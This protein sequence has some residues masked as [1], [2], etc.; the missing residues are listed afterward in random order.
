MCLSQFYT[1]PS[2]EGFKRG[3]QPE[4]KSLFYTIFFL[5]IYFSRTWLYLHAI[6]PLNPGHHTVRD[7]RRVFAV[8]IVVR[9]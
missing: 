9:S 3:L 1:F 6:A 8:Q 5:L 4:L 7:E 2:G